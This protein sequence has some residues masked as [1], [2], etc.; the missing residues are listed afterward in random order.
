MIVIEKIRASRYSTTRQKLRSYSSLLEKLHQ[1]NLLG[2]LAIYPTIGVDALPAQYTKVIGLDLRR[3]D[4]YKIT[5]HLEPILPKKDLSSFKAKLEQNLTFVSG[6]DVSD[7]EKL[8]A[9]LGAYRDITPKSI[10]L[11][12]LFENAFLLEWNRDNERHYP[13]DNSACAL[14]RANAWTQEM[15]QWL[16]AKDTVITFDRNLFPILS[17]QPD[18]TEIKTGLRDRG[19]SHD[20]VYKVHSAPII[21][22]PH[23]VRVYEKT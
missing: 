16:N 9:L 11:K 15:T 10:I 20:F 3:Y 14:N 17:D 6:V 8:I 5:V 7:T 18:L 1:K 23:F 13:A 19:K 2:R 12:G 21:L 22:L 4:N